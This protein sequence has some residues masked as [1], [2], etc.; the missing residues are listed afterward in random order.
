VDGVRL[1]LI[2]GWTLI[3][4]SGTEPVIRI[5]V[6]AK[7]RKRAKEL[8]ERSSRFVINSLEGKI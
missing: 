3:R 1:D 8:L 6:E 4:P 5:T 2:D 7:M